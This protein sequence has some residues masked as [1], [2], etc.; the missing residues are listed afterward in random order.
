MPGS[1]RTRRTLREMCQVGGHTKLLFH[2]DIRLLLRTQPT[3]RKWIILEVKLLAADSILILWG[4]FW[5]VKTVRT[6]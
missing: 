1:Y 6:L 2:G 5:K 4:G 3:L